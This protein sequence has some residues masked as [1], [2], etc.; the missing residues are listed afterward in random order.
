MPAIV[1][2]ARPAGAEYSTKYYVGWPSD[3]DDYANP[4]PTVAN[5]AWILTK[6]TPAG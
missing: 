3:D 6:L 2:D 4:Q 5:A 1:V